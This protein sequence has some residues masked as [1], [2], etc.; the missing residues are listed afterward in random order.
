MP[1]TILDSRKLLAF[2]TLAR[3]LSFTHAAKELGL[4]QSAVSHAIKALERDLGC[5]LFER[6]GR[7]VV[8]TPAGIQLLQRTAV[9]LAE[10]TGARQDLAAFTS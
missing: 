6:V 2:S 3:V 10:M 4:T 8:I 1:P 7:S 5:R 9:I